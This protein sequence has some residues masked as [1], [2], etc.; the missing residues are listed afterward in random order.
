[1]LPDID[2]Q[3]PDA[4]GSEHRVWFHEGRIWKLAYAPKTV[5]LE[6][7]EFGSLPRLRLVQDAP[8][9]AMNL[10]V[11]EPTGCSVALTFALKVSS[12][13]CPY[14]YGTSARNFSNP[15]R[16]RGHHARS[17]IRGRRNPYQGLRPP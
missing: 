5:E 16:D 4:Q 10:A 7:A 17:W 6:E 13:E 3:S 15:S 12:T 1:M 9:P 2:W 11:K 8:S 14:L